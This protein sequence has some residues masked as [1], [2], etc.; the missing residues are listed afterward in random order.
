MKEHHGK[1]RKNRIF[2][3]D[4][5]R[6][7]SIFL[8]I[9]HHFIYDLRHILGLDVF[10][11]QDT[12][13][14]INFI[15]GIFLCIFVVVSGICCQF[16][17]NNISRSGK[18][19]IATFLLSVG[20]AIA[21]K[22]SGLELYIFFNMLYVLTAAIF[23][24]GLF[25]LFY[26][27]KVKK[28]DN[29]QEQLILFNRRFYIF[30][31]LFASGGIAAE[32]LHFVF[33]NVKSYILL[34]LGENFIPDSTP[35]MGDYLP[36]FPWIGFFFVGVFIGRVY[37]SERKSIFKKIPKTIA[38]SLS[39]FVWIGRNALW[40]YLFHQPVMLGILYG[41]RMMNLL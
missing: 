35:G 23:I 3:L 15:R 24:E 10:A 6:G 30:L 32:Q 5:L 20:M 41:L 11:F 7:F 9:L 4:V 12:P 36:L 39:P 28:I 19:A 22:I 18:L 13:F 25:D 2:E 27:K 17:R 33:P 31:L 40:V 14:F 37:Y 1:D 16:S 34:P 29:D 26:R 21:S 38:K 8:M